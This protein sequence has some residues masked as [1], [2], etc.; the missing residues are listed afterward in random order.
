MRITDYMETACFPPGKNII[1][2]T[3]ILPARC[4]MLLLWLHG[5]QERASQI[6]SHPILE[7]LAYDH[8]IAVVIPNVPD[9]YYM[10]QPWNQALT[11]TFLVSEFLPALRAKHALP[12]STA[13][14]GI[15]MGG[16]GSLLLGSRHP[17]CFEKILSISGAFIIEDLLIGNPEVIGNSANA[18]L[19]FQTLFG[20]IPS[21]ETNPERNP[22]VSA[23]DTLAAGTLPPVFLA[24][25]TDDMLYSRNLRLRRILEKEGAS[26]T[27]TEAE[28]SH[29]W[30]CFEKILP[31]AFTW[32]AED[33][34]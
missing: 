12:A 23:L 1:E 15:S 34:I 3:L 30:D 9:T 10:D 25:G 24:C 20:D 8:G 6:L 2:Y 14:A 26:I 18:I 5:Y 22:E 28:G 31:E 7:Q 17:N 27:W 32:L 21:L 16:F 29:H 4:R 11:E 19:H 33:P 13:I